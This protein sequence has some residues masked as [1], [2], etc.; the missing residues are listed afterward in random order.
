MNQQQQ[1]FNQDLAHNTSLTQQN[2]SMATSTQYDI[3]N[4]FQR[5][6]LNPNQQNPDH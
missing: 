2:W 1:Q 3:S 4:I 5:M 6:N